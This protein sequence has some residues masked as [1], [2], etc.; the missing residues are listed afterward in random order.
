[1][2]FQNSRL[3]MSHFVG[4]PITCCETPLS[5]FYTRLREY[6]RLCSKGPRREQKGCLLRKK[7]TIQIKFRNMHRLARRFNGMSPACGAGEKDRTAF[8]VSGAPL[9]TR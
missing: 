5:D 3:I 6:K 2:V 1:M 7:A 9:L 8:S 4:C